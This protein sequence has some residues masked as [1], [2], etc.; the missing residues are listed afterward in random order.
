MRLIATNNRSNNDA[1]ITE[2]L[3]TLDSTS[4][5]TVLKRAHM[6]NLLRESGNSCWVSTVTERLTV[7]KARASELTPEVKSR[8]FKTMYDK[9]YCR[10]PKLALELILTLDAD[11]V[12]EFKACLDK[13]FIGKSLNVILGHVVGTSNTETAIAKIESIKP[14]TDVLEQ[15]VFADID[16]TVCCGWKDTR[17]PKATIYPGSGQFIQAL[18]RTDMEDLGKSLGVAF[19]T[20]RPKDG[21]GL[22]DHYTRNSLEK[23]GL[24]SATILYGD[25]CHLFPESRIGTKKF[26]NFENN[27][28]LY[29]EGKFT[30]VGDSGQKDTEVGLEMLEKHPDQML[31]VFIHNVTGM[32][33]MRKRR[34]AKK[35][36]WVFENYAEAARI[37]LK[38]G[39]IESDKARDVGTACIRKFCDIDFADDSQ[40]KALFK[41][42]KQDLNRLFREVEVR[43]AIAA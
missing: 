10:K 28:R 20:A 14:K 41:V 26:S 38:E 11:N 7:L 40:K 16:D 2:I 6:V 13:R 17:Y 21:F 5:N 37:A 8:V 29:P 15:R 43:D 23:S 9:S 22:M 4:L 3:A 1:A 34:L 35:G 27:L 30:F 25:F 31:G 24:A 19:L 33:D 12:R 39:I 36:V 42:L 32:S 18:R